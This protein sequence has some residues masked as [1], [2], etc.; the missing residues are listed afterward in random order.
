MADEVKEEADREIT[1]VTGGVVQ[2]HNAV[3]ALKGWIKSQG[4]DVDGLAKA[5][6]VDLLSTDVPPGVRRV[7]TLR[8]ETGKASVAKLKPMIA[9]A[10]D[11]HR[12]RQ[13][14]QY[15][16]AANGRWAGRKLQPHN[17]VRNTPDE[18]YIEEV[19]AL[20]RKG[21]W[22]TIDAVYGPPLSVLSRCLRGFFLAPKG[23]V[24]IAGDLSGI[25]AR[26]AAWLSGEEWKLKAFRES[27]TK[28]GP[29]VYELAYS[30]SFNVPVETVKNP[31]YERSIGKVMELAFGYQGGV[32][33]FHLM[34]KSHGLKVSDERAEGY[35]VAWRAAHPRIKQ[36]WYDYQRAAINAVRVPGEAF[37]AGYPGRAVKFKTAGSFLWCLLPSGRALCYPYP[38]ILEGEYGPQLTH[39][40]VPSQADASKGKVIDDSMNSPRWSR[41]IAHGG[42]LMGNIDPAICRDLLVDSMLT[43]HGMGAAV[44]LH[45]HD[46]IVIEVSAEKAEGAREKMQEIMRSPP[47][48][49]AGFPL[50]CECEVMRR[51]G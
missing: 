33:A 39:M 4:V 40:G 28:Q 37:E 50:F 36:T 15:H 26:G 25:E 18:S 1:K 46:E 24:L 10:G 38:K 51:Y 20:I 29:G 9:I 41:M 47:E 42:T 34:A 43:L 5:D 32:G 3:L 31:S 27:D 19:F 14:L 2:T 8:Q 7:L 13:I 11:D 22:R 49:A 44:V 45:V 48:W 23:K 30:K 21:E 17:F 6:V 16:G 12:V 35:K